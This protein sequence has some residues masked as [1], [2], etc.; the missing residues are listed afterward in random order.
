[1]KSNRIVL[2]PDI[3]KRCQEFGAGVVSRFKN[4]QKDASLFYATHGFESDERGW[5]LSKMAECAAAL[6]FDMSVECLNWTEKADEHDLVV[7]QTKIQVKHTA[8][9]SRVLLWPFN[10]IDRFDED[11]NVLLLVKG[12]ERNFLLAG[13]IGKESYRRRHLVSNGTKVSKGSWILDQDELH[14]MNI[15]PGRS[16][17][18]RKHYC[19]CGEWASRGS[20]IG[21]RC[22]RHIG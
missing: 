13:W 3:I 9:T 17:D 6:W 20:D 15:F 18:P 2:P 14:R 4:G 21:R 22:Q 10:K 16:D 11:F 12:D 1:M 8:F 7:G 5:A 19:W